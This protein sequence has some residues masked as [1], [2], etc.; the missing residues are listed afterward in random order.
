VTEGLD[1]RAT[2]RYLQMSPR[3]VR[4]VLDL[5]RGQ[6]AVAAMQ[7]LKFTNKVAA[8]A[9]E[10]LLKSAIANAEK[11]YG[12]SKDNLYV[13]QAYANEGPI[14]RWRRYGARVRFKPI[15]KRQSHVTLVLRDRGGSPEVTPSE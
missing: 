10:K 3:K 9:L 13:H 11:N 2:H 6:D 8:D 1:V 7:V 12:L 5:I 15:R 14:R 4:P